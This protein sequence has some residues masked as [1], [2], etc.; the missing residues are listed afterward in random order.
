MPKGK[1]LEDTFEQLVELGHLTAKKTVKSVVQ[2]LNPLSGLVSN[3]GNNTQT[4]PQQKEKN[5]KN[6]HTPLNFEDLQ[7]KFQNQ[8]KAKT[9][10]LR[11]RLFQMVRESEKKVVSEKKQEE[12]ERKRKEEAEKQE[13]RR[14]EEEKRRQQE[15]AIPMGKI[16]R[17]IFNPK[18]M[19][20][21]QHVETKAA[22]GKQ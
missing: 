10:A 6:N 15:G 21:R 8:E 22:V 19:A 11:Q 18:K 13:K 3:E 7:K 17:S 4:N 1:I 20:Q 12:I 2:T 9:E 16:R 14:I 5:S